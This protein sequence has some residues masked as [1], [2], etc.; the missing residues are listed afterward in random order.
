MATAKREELENSVTSAA[1]MS[2]ADAIAAAKHAPKTTV[3]S[4]QEVDE[5]GFVLLP[6]KRKLVGKS[7]T[8]IDAEDTYDAMG[9]YWVTTVRIVVGDKAL[10][11][12]DS[13]SGIRHQILKI[14]EDNVKMTTW[15]KGLRV[16]DYYVNDRPSATFYLDDTAL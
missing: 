11:I 12:R 1:P 3:T 10:F 4:A 2:A 14:G 5:R 9:D 16:S 15:P 7:F 13:S 6:D 8:I